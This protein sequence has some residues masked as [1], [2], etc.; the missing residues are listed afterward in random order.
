MVDHITGSVF[1]SL[2]GG[3]RVSLADGIAS[4]ILNMINQSRSAIRFEQV[5][6]HF[7]PVIS[8]QR[9]S[10]AFHKTLSCSDEMSDDVKIRDASLGMMVPVI[11]CIMIHLPMMD[12]N[13]CSKVCKLWNDIAKCMKQERKDIFWYCELL[14]DQ[15]SS[16]SEHTDG[17]C[18]PLEQSFSLQ[19][20]AEVA[21]SLTR[22]LRNSRSQPKLALLFYSTG[23]LEVL[24]QGQQQVVKRS[25]WISL[26]A[27]SPP[28]EESYTSVEKV[29]TFSLSMREAVE[30][31]FIDAILER[32]KQR[33]PDNDSNIMHAFAVLSMRPICF[34]SQKDIE[35]WAKS[36]QGS[37]NHQSD[38]CIGAVIASAATGRLPTNSTS[39]YDVDEATLS[40]CLFDVINYQ[41]TLVWSLNSHTD[42][43][44]I[45][46]EVVEG[47]SA[48]FVPEI[49]GVE[50]LPFLLGKTHKTISVS[51]I[52]DEMLTKLTNIKPGKEVKCL[53]LFSS[54]YR[55]KHTEL[56]T[57]LTSQLFARQ[58]NSFAI[59]GGYLENVLA[60]QGLCG[61]DKCRIGAKEQTL[62]IAICGDN[63]EAASTISDG[64]IES[65]ESAL[66]K[67]KSC[68]FKEKN[69]IG[70]MFA[71]CSR[72]KDFY[73]KSNVE[74]D[75]FRK[76]FP[77]TPLFGFFGSGEIGF[78]KI[79]NEIRTSKRQKVDIT[80]E[81]IIHSYTTPCYTKSLPKLTNHIAPN[82]LYQCTTV[83]Q[84]M[85]SYFEKGSLIEHINQATFSRI[86]KL[87]ILRSQTFTDMVPM[88]QRP[89]HE[90]Q[91][92]SAPWMTIYR[93]YNNVISQSDGPRTIEG[94]MRVGPKAVGTGVGLQDPCRA[95]VCPVAPSSDTTVPLTTPLLEGPSASLRAT[96][97]PSGR[98]R[99]PDSIPPDEN[100]PPRGGAQQSRAKCPGCPHT[101]QAPWPASLP[102]GFGADVATRPVDTFPGLLPWGHIFTKCGPP[103]L[104]QA[105]PTLG[106]PA[107]PSPTRLNA[108]SPA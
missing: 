85:Y 87:Y 104:K 1:L 101:K 48:L 84:C 60:L 108:P 4:T 76:T 16:N 67:L 91:S 6:Y 54:D 72:G 43:H 33:F 23:K 35:T 44:L 5:G 71:C 51:A 63:V 21:M 73:N 14:L 28:R 56:V 80:D 102:E 105:P 59:G 82:D 83:K 86:M 2:I 46:A 55:G 38:V 100:T 79:P 97:R 52:D 31:D 10:F 65:V 103:H 7:P 62:G 61:I 74:A 47:I 25:I 37:Y 66:N 30:G 3:Y 75:L 12:L 89:L 19:S 81:D 9:H 8:L 29:V 11:K 27:C 94:G 98:T 68:G 15:N 64:E 41:T 49:P 95:D 69:L 18:S 106:G 70:L 90:G 96:L 34:C 13:N 50:F 88:T 24:M 20:K 78:Q 93:L 22:T 107:V 17:E 39:N 57:A 26:G 99:G 36:D 42:G 40:L 92:H 45:E 32:L 77:T 53:L 58:K